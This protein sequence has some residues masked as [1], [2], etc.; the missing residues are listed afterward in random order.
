M[1]RSFL[2]LLLAA[3]CWAQPQNQPQFPNKETDWVA[4]DFEFHAGE[5]MAE[6]R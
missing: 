5:K 4:H 2:A 3:A 6:L 1:T